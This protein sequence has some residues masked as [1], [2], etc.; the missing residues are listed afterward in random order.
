M[1]QVKSKDFLNKSWR[2][3][4]IGGGAAGF[5]AAITA[6]EAGVQQVLILES[7]DNPLNKVRISGGGR[8]NIT[9]ACWNPKDLIRHYPRGNYSL[10]NPLST[11]GAGDAIAWFADHGLRLI[12]EIDG[13]MFP[14]SHSSSSVINTLKRAAEKVGICIQSNKYVE[15]ISIKET[16]EVE[17]CVRDRDKS[18]SHVLSCDMI[19]LATGSHPSG[20]RIAVNLGHTVI[21]PV[22][23]LFTISLREKAFQHLA[24]VVID[25]VI[26]KLN[27]PSGCF[28]DK[29]PILITHYGLSG[30]VVLKLT[31]FAARALKEINYQTSVEVDWSGGRSSMELYSIIASIREEHAKRQVLNWRPWPE[32]SR[33]LWTYL[34]QNLNLHLDKR[35]ADVS[36]T[37]IQLIITILKKSVYCMEGKGPF[38]EEF[39]TSGGVDL[40]EIHLPTMQSKI[41][42]KVYFAGEIMNVDGI[43]GGFNFQHCWSSGWI[44]GKSIAESLL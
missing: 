24:G 14:E 16:Q 31:A 18:S 3:I 21:K 10:L 22:P 34:V 19:V 17:L 40:D 43:T 37:E 7:T 39:V 23:S 36:K 6:A 29:G 27:L 9:H 30:P 38:G 28:T 11:F 44:A 1:S 5:M 20:Y 25:P 8:C 13:R 41:T 2:L 26:L 15:M 32:L 33:R 12:E 35:W 4:V 42:S